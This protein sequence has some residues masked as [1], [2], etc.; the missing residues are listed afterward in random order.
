VANLVPGFLWTPIDVGTRAAR[1]KGRGAI[2]HVAVS[3]SKNLIPGPLASRPSDWHFYFPKIGPAR[4]YI[5]LDVQCWS[6]AGG[7]PTCPA[8]ESE[9]GMGTA[10]QVNAEPWTHDQIVSGAM[11]LRHLHQTEGTPYQD[12][13]NSLPSSRGLGVH[14]YGISPWRVPGGEV[15]SSVNG[16]LCPGDAKAAQVATIVDLAASGQPLTYGTGDVWT[17]PAVTPTVTP[18]PA[19]VP[20][21]AHAWV[22]DLPAWDLPAGHWFGNKAGGATQHGGFYIGER[23]N[24]K[25]IQRAFIVLGCVPGVSD[26]RS[27]WADGL[28]ET[29]TDV[30][31]RNWFARY[32]PGQ[33]YTDRVYADDYAALQRNIA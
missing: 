20:S 28:W 2:G 13:R 26:Y 24:I 17:P 19:P 31:C 7:N 3:N 11:V 9:G 10:A 16:K 15:W 8:W 25:G 30:A 33:Q 29:A 14:R 12:M 18:T 6:S 4:Q 32:R 5:D 27:G 21:P 23:D 1:R 22:P